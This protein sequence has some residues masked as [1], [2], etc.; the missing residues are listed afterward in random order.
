MIKVRRIDYSPDEFLV[1]TAHMTNELVGAYWRLCS[2]MYSRGGPIADDPAMISHH[3][4]CNTRT[5]ARLRGELIADGKIA[6]TGGLLSNRR[7]MVELDKVVSRSIENREN[8]K[9]GGR[10]PKDKPGV[11]PTNLPGTV[12]DGESLAKPDGSGKVPGRFR[13]GSVTTTSAGNNNI[14]KPNGSSGGN[15]TTTTT[16]TTISPDGERL[17]NLTPASG[18]DP[19]DGRNRNQDPD[20]LFGEWYAAYPKK[21]SRGAARKAYRAALRKVGPAVLLGGAKRYAAENV[22]EDKQFLR[23]PATWLNG[24]G[25][26]DEPKKHP[27]S[28]AG[29]LFDQTSVSG[30]ALT[31]EAERERWRKNVQIYVMTHTW[32]GEGP[33]P[34]EPGCRVPVELRSEFPDIRWSPE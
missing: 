31:P 32:H 1:G 12:Q 15:P 16:T 7:T 19:S 24:E 4:R 20:A 18:H 5:W 28:A 34:G 21:A 13:E 3:L 11:E 6:A 17:L 10:P 23:H 22:G 8:G 30:A 25:W 29:T 33:R 2:L 26:A 14:A 27:K 9:K